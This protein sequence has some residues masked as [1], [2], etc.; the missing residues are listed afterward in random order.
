MPFYEY[1]CN[2]CGKVFELLQSIKS[3]PIS[4][5]IA[6]GG[7]V[8][9]LVSRSSFQFRGSGWYVT[10][11]RGKSDDSPKPQKNDEKKTEGKKENAQV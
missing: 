5:C 4:V 2:K 10:D 11:Y 6:C 8:E 1:K 3:D 9:R 7:Q